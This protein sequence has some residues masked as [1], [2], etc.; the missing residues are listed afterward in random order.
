MSWMGNHWHIVLY[1]G[2][3]APNLEEVAHRYNSYYEKKRMPLDPVMDSEKCQQFAEQLNDISFFMRQI[4]QKFTFYINRMH[5][6]RGTLWADRFKSTILE[7]ERAL[8]NC[9]KY[10][11]RWLNHWKKGFCSGNSVPISGSETCHKKTT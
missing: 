5:N 7:G 1:V 9:V 11:D 6:R 4:H 10:L 8:W 3:K 2:D